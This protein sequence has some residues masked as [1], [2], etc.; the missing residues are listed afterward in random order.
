MALNTL[1][2]TR[3]QL[4]TFLKSHDLIKQ[5]EKLV[6]VVAEVSESPDTTGANL[7]AGNADSAANEAL[8]G[9]ARFA[10][11]ASTDA[12]AAN[13][14]AAL[15]LDALNRIANALELLALSPLEFTQTQQ[16]LDLSPP[17]QVGTMG[18]Q[19][20]DRVNITGGKVVARLV[21]NQTVLLET[22]VALT[23]GSAL[24]SG[25]LLNAPSAGDPTK[26]VPIDDDGTIRFI[27]TW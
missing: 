14:K 19:Q 4:A 7:Q 16:V 5:F 6:A 25:T 3:D 18:E 9:V 8:A 17:T 21:N 11:D 27:P 24:A 23:D 13:Q 26:W 20:A 1:K 2:I 10:Q 15:A 22:T 12:E